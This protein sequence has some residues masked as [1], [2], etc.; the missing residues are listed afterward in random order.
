MGVSTAHAAIIDLGNN[1]HDTSSGL[2]WL[3][4][5]ETTNMSYLDVSSELSTGGLYDGYRYANALE[6]KDFYLNYEATG[7]TLP[8]FMNMIGVTLVWEVPASDYYEWFSIG[9]IG[10]DT[11]QLQEGVGW[12]YANYWYDEGVYGELTPSGM[13]DDIE[14]VDVR[15]M[16]VGSFLVMSPV[17]EPA[18]LPMALLGIGMIGVAYRRRRLAVKTGV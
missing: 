11:S 9:Y 1:T 15:R 12:T 13:I 3:D 5:T 8:E 14:S 2:M 17:P 7:G 18:A 10:D 6:V 16:D 4:L